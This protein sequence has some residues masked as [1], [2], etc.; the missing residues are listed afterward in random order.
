MN[1]QKG[2][3]LN[4]IISTTYTLNFLKFL[5]QIRFLWSFIPSHSLFPV[6]MT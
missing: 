4:A 6:K 1:I 5:T 3:I 2:D